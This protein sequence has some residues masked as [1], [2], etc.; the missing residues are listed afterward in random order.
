MP[1]ILL[2]IEEWKKRLIDLTR[3]NQLI[4]FD[5]SKKNL[6]EIK[7]PNCETIFENLRNEKGFD[8]WLPPEKKEDMEGALGK[9]ND[10]FEEEIV[11][12]PDENDLAF[13]L[14]KRKDIEKRL[15]TI[16][17]RASSDYQEKGLRT[18]VIAL[19]LLHWKEKEGGEEICSPLLLIPIEIFQATP[20]EPYQIEIS[21]EEAIL[22]PAIQ[23]KLN[24]DFKI[25]LPSPDL[26]SESFSLGE[27]FSN[28]EKIGKRD[29]WKVENRAFLGIFTFHKIRTGA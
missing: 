1:D 24:W 9:S 21:E 3:R 18:S 2:Q 7:Q 25:G 13:T 23:V 29:G 5:R 19:G 28:V 16:F 12:Q 10:L 4:F 8:V 6:L 14:D 17:R 11:D 22:N 26:T 20:K 27:Y 15:K